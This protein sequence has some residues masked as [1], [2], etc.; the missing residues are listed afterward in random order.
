MQ[1]EF[2]ILDLTSEVFDED[3][4]AVQSGK[5][6]YHPVYLQE[7]LHHF[8]AREDYERCAVLRDSIDEAVED[9]TSEGLRQQLAD[10]AEQVDIEEIVIDTEENLLVITYEDKV[11]NMGYLKAE[12][13][14]DV[15]ECLKETGITGEEA[16]NLFAWNRQDRWIPQTY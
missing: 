13:M 3:Y 12:W 15:V 9:G 1:E 2:E 4:E 10:D 14:L 6:M 11:Y 16:I 7:M 5:V 8:E